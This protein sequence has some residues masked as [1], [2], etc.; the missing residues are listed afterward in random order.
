MLCYIYFLL[1][2]LQKHNNAESATDQMGEIV[3][4]KSELGSERIEGILET[5]PHSKI[6]NNTTSVETFFCKTMGCPIYYLPQSSFI[7]C[8][9]SNLARIVRHPVVTEKIT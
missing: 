6:K 9:K 4:L 3:D 8:T 1:V 7:K 5:L 2:V